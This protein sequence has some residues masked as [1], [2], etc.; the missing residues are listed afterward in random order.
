MSGFNK[1]VSLPKWGDT[2]GVNDTIYSF[3]NTC[4]L[5]TWF[6]IIRYLDYE[7]LKS[8]IEYKNL[9]KLI[10]LIFGQDY[11]GARMFVASFIKIMS[12]RNVIDFFGL[13]SNLFVLPFLSEFIINTIES[14]CSNLQCPG[15]KQRVHLKDCLEVLPADDFSASVANWFIGE[16]ETRCGLKCFPDYQNPKSFQDVFENRNTVTKYV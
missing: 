9:L 11:I 4:A 6:S 14:R 13:E 15:G 7:E 8:S 3:T 10:Q 1:N 2:Y 16:K 5:D 12:K